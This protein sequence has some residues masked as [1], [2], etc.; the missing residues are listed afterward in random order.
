MKYYFISLILCQV[1]KNFIKFCSLGINISLW[2]SR[3]LII[4]C[5]HLEPNSPSSVHTSRVASVAQRPPGTYVTIPR[6]SPP[7]GLCIC[8]FL[9]PECTSPRIHKA[10]TSA[11]LS[12]CLCSNIPLLSESSIVR[13]TPLLTRHVLSCSH[14]FLFLLPISTVFLFMCLL[15]VS[16]HRI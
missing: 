4:L 16:F 14:C 1:P 2:W 13:E 8:C 10:H 9:C 12:S 11:S 6:T 15:S 5:L 7:R 3:A